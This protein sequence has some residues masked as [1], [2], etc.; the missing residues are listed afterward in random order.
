MVYDVTDANSFRNVQ[1]WIHEIDRN[2]GET[3]CKLLIGNK[4]DLSNK[5]AVSTQE[6]QD[7]ADSMGIEFLECSAKTSHNVEQSFMSMTAQIKA[8]MMAQPQRAPVATKPL[9]TPINLKGKSL[10]SKSCC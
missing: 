6:G 9:P 5:R 1:Q 3:C 4:A 2:A 10:N 7:F 8:K